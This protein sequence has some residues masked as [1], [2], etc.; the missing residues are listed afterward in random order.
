[1]RRVSIPPPFLRAIAFLFLSVAAAAAAPALKAEVE[2]PVLE[3]LMGGCSLNCAFRWKVEALSQGQ[4]G[5]AVK[6]L[7][8]ESPQTPWIATGP[9]AKSAIGTKLRLSFP[10]KLR[11]EEEGTVPLYG[12][13]LINGHWKTEALWRH[14]GRIR[15]ARLY[16][17]DRAIGDIAFA[18]SR[19]WQR[20]VFDD[21]F[22]RS[23]DALTL[24]IL[25]TYEG[26]GGGVAISEIVLQGAH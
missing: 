7:N 22:I 1:M 23:G 20:V 19:R 13:D 24:E 2:E 9:S 21:I 26:S 25:E 10:A 14:H 17:N 11:P 8:D 6:T 3:E 5:R 16:Y 12:L 4:K 15:K 18:D